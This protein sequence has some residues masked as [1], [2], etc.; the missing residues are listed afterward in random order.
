MDSAK[1]VDPAEDNH[2]IE[3]RV[4]KH[5]TVRLLRGRIA[6]LD[7]DLSYNEMKGIAYEDR[8]KAKLSRQA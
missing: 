6:S 8:L 4:P 7:R 3:L 5:S 1:Q 2:T